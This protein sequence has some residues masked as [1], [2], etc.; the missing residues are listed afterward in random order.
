MKD[1]IVLIGMPGVGKS[2][3]GVILA[4]MIGYQFIDADLLIQKQEGKLLH[5]IIAEKGTDGF[6]EIEERVNASIEA[7]H[8]IIATGGSVVYGKKAMEHLS[9]IGTVVY[10]KVPYDTLEKRLEDIK[11]RGV[12]L[13]EGQTLRTLYDER[14]PLYEKY[15]DIEISEDDLNVE[16]T[17]EKLLERLN[18]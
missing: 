10:L 17:V 7:S 12:V 6:I 16:Q 14:T 8:T 15:A 1:N 11:G 2:T 5:E 3:V 13:K 9:R 4:K 18:K